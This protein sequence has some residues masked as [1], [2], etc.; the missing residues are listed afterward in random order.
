MNNARVYSSAE[1]IGAFYR[2]FPNASP[3]AIMNSRYCAATRAWVDA[4]FSNYFW[5]FEIARGQLEYRK[6][7]NQCEHYALRAAL[8][9]VD[10]FRQMP[11]D[12]VPA[13]AE[14]IAIAAVKYSQQAGTPAAGWHEVNTWFLGGVWC[15]WEP[16]TRKFFDFTEAERLTVTQPIIP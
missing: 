10:L 5:N 11:D 4:R 2:Q 3:A 7:G 15:A 9:A 14:S 16:Q 8:E 13:D 12:A 1:L 6:R